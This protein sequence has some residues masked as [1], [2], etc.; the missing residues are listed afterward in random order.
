MELHVTELSIEDR[1]AIVR[2]SRPGRGNSW[3]SRMNAEYRWLMER[4][5]KDPAVR[6]I[7]VTG[8]GRQFCVGAD[9]KALDHHARSAAEYVE[10]SKNEEMAR[11]GHGVRADFDHEMVWHWGLRKTVICAINGACAGIAV[12]LAAFCDLRY[13]VAGAKFTTATPKLGLPAEYGISW[14]LPRIVGLTHAA[15]ILLTGRVFT[16][17]EAQAMGFLNG[18]LPAEEFEPGIVKLARGIAASVS[19]IAARTAKRQL[20]A[21]LLTHDVGQAIEDSKVLT[22]KLLGHPD[23]KEGAAAMQEKRPPRFNDLND[24]G[25]E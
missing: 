8:V 19:P 7:I 4:C 23:H 24:S 25:S 18:V 12:S 16:A 22:G 6:V 13:A 2:L 3:T 21:Q 5:D 10:A 9:F 14:V 1:V 17:E 15:D 20:Y 11:P